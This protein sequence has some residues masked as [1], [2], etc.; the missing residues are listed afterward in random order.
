M[1]TPM[2]QASAE[3]WLAFASHS[4]ILTEKQ[5]ERIYKGLDYVNSL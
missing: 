2:M 1:K 5:R 4:K 3:T